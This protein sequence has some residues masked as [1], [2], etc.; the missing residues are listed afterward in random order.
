MLAAALSP[1][2]VAS[3]VQGCGNTGVSG[4]GGA[5]A[6]GGSDAPP[7]VTTVLHPD[8]PPLPGQST[9]EVTITTGIHVA[10]AYHVALCTPVEYATNP[11]SGGDHWGAWAAFKTYDAPIPREL[12]VHDMEHGAI[13]FLHHCQGACPDVI[14]ALEQGRDA[15]SGD[16]MCLQIPD[17][18]TERVLITPDPKIEAPIAAAA[19]GAT[20]TATCIDVPSLRDFAKA[21]YAKATENLCAQGQYASDPCSDAGAGGA[22]GGT[23][24]AGGTSSGGASSGGGSGAADGG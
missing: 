10:Q 13:V 4:D 9:C 2:G 3:L 24:G 20:Y 16:P 11:P 21:H 5:S 8:A 6:D 15:V 17:G 22:T 1:V 18:P 14:A 19:W 7:A 12:Y 23:A